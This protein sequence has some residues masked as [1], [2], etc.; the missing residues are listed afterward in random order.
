MTLFFLQQYLTTSPRNVT[1]FVERAL[2]LLLP[3]EYAARQALHHQELVAGP[4]VPMFVCTTAFPCV[5]CPLYV[6]EP[7]YR[8]MVRRCVDSGTR[9][10]GIAACLDKDAGLDR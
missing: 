8:V 6:Y 10:F 7:R 5:A 3:G 2:R 1:E 9:Q 4:H